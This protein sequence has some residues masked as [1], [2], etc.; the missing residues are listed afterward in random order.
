MK[1]KLGRWDQY[2][3]GWPERKMYADPKTAEMAGEFLR[4]PEILDIE[5]WGCGFGGFEDYVGEW[6]HYIGID[7]SKTPYASKIEDLVHYRS[8]VDAIH[9]RHVLEHNEEWKAIL[10][11]FLESF[12]KRGVLTI[13][14]PMN[15]GQKK[16]RVYEDFDG[17]GRMIDVWFGEGEIEGLIRQHP[18]ITVEAIYGIES[19]SQ[20]GAEYMFLLEK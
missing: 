3:Q 10:N 9:L 4:I 2:Y 5:D 19:K 8:T 7:G 15:K 17:L 20:Y 11:N 1:S 16:V 18:N 6:Q 14:T 12:Q 13:F